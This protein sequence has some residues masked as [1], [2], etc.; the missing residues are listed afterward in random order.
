MLYVAESLTSRQP[1]EAE[2]VMA[3]GATLPVVVWHHP[4]TNLP[5]LPVGVSLSVS[6]DR[7]ACIPHLDSL[8]PG[9]HLRHHCDTGWSEIEGVDAA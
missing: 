1:Q 6:S 9:C 5:K 4:P 8:S 7:M 2:A 3:A